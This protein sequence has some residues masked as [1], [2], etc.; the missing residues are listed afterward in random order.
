MP[1][2]VAG[3]KTQNGTRKSNSTINDSHVD[4]AVQSDKISIS[5]AQRLKTPIKR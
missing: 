4:A 2:L 3:N 1:S 5:R